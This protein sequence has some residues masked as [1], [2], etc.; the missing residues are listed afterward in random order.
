M[1]HGTRIAMA[2][3]QQWCKDHNNA[4]MAINNGHRQ[5]QL[6]MQSKMTVNDGNQ[7][8]CKDSKGDLA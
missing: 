4:G 3:G 1:E 6:M 8:W 2:L 5:R 7:R